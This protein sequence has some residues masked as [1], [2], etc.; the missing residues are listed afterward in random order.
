MDTEQFREHAR[1]AVEQFGRAKPEGKA[2]DVFVDHLDY[3]ISDPPHLGDLAT[4]VHDAAKHIGGGTR[5]LHYLSIPPF[6]MTDVVTAIG[7]SRPRR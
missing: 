1:D 4:A 6:A 5:I 3:V 7:G 2:W